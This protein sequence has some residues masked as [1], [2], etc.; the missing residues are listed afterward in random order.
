[1]SRIQWTTALAALLVLGLVSW[2][3]S[4]G[5]SPAPKP[6]AQAEAPKVAEKPAAREEAAPAVPVVAAAS[7][8]KTV[9][10]LVV[11]PPQAPMPTPAI[12]KPNPYLEP[13]S[14]KPQPAL[15]VPEGLTNLALGKPVT[16]SDAMPIIGDL[17]M[18]TDGDKT[19]LDGMYVELAPGRQWAQIDLGA[20]SLIHAI[21]VWHYNMQKYI[22]YH[23]VVIQVADDADFIQNVQTVFNNDYDGSSSLGIGKDLEYFD[24]FRGR[25]FDAKGAKGRYVRLY[26]NGNTM[27][28]MN[29]YVEVEVWGKPAK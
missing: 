5:S 29:Q 2:S 19:G 10:L 22:V 17:K 25:V 27:N 6:E 26:S 11:R 20:T 1:M 15:M 13:Y 4:P 7:A 14:D 23:D 24:D 12:V 21:V 9:P 8:E 16:S 18:V 3:C 28:D